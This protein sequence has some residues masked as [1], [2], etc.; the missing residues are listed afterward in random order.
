MDVAGATVVSSGV[1][2]GDRL[3]GIIVGDHG[4]QDHAEG[5]ERRTDAVRPLSPT[6]ERQRILLLLRRRSDRLARP[7][8]AGEKDQRPDVGAVDWRVCTAEETER[9]DHAHRNG[10]TGTARKRPGNSAIISIVLFFI[11]LS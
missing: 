4:G 1:I 11:G 9:A 3:Y 8:F 5:G 7:K 6:G 10:R 2:D